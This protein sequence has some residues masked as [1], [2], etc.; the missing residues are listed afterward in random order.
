M[1]KIL[2]I[3]PQAVTGDEREKRACSGTIVNDK[4]GQTLQGQ[5]TPA[6]KREP[7]IC[8]GRIDDIRE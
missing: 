2:T 8:S 1:G 6:G 3:P 5:L 7:Q 4:S